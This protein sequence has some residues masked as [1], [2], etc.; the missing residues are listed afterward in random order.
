MIQLCDLEYRIRISINTG[1]IYAPET[2]AYFRVHSKSTTSANNTER[3]YFKDV[4]DPLLL[5][6]EFS[7]KPHYAPLRSCALG[8]PSQRNL[9]REFSERALGVHAS[10]TA[11]P[12]DANQSLLDYWNKLARVYPRLESGMHLMPGRFRRWF[13]RTITWRLHS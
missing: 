7:F 3:T 6:H 12:A 10:A 2:L 11:H 5:Q 13:E 8:S 9:R 4:I 1:I